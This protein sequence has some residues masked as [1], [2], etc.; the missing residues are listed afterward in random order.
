MEH[1][2]WLTLRLGNNQSIGP[3]VLSDLWSNACETNQSSVTRDTMPGKS[4]SYALHAPL[5]L[6]YPKRAEL[7]M[8]KLLEEAGYTFTLGSLADRPAPQPMRS[9]R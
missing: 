6:A 8:R 2:R 3:K 4:T 1:M 9:T 7:R 5:S